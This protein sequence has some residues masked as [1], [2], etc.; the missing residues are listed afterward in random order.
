M[1]PVREGDLDDKLP[2]PLS[3]LL[4][5][6]LLAPAGLIGTTHCDPE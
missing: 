6:L 2:G 4:G 3:D 1:S 5:R